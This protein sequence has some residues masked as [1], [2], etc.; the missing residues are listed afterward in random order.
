MD[1]EFIARRT[2]TR[3]H[4]AETGVE[5]AAI[6]VSALLAELYEAKKEL[7][8]AGTVAAE[9]TARVGRALSLLQDAHAELVGTHHGL[10]AIARLLKIPVKMIGWKPSSAVRVGNISAA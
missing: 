1:Q 6:K 10:S 8:L 9:E 2:A 5:D 4:A 3:M 7:G